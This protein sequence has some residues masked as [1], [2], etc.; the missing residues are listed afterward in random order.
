MIAA[1]IH[2]V[3]KMLLYESRFS[4]TFEIDKL[5]EIARNVGTGKDPVAMYRM[6]RDALDRQYPGKICTQRDPAWC[7]EKGFL[8]APLHLSFSEVVSL[9]GCPQPFAHEHCGPAPVESFCFI[10]DGEILAQHNARPE[11]ETKRPGDVFYAH[12]M[13]SHYI[14]SG[15]FVW[16]LKYERGLVWLALP[17]KIISSHIA[18]PLCI[19]KGLTTYFTCAVS[20]LTTKAKF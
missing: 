1:V 4:G 16:T 5:Q 2:M 13:M 15:R 3:M 17:M 19:L 6:L 10:L 12:S 18:D 7:S 20:Q 14:S 8:C 9:V 11:I